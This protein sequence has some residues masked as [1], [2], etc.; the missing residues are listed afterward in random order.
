MGKTVKSKTST[1]VKVVT[2][3]SCDLPPQIVH[4]L[5]I[6]IVPLYIQFGGKTYCDGVDI[7]SDRLYHELAHSSEIPK[8]SAPSPGDF[9]KVYNNLAREANQII[10]IHLSQGYSA[11]F[12]AAMLARSYMEDECRV[13][14]IDS[15]SVS[16]GL[17][18]LVIA[19]AK[20]AQE[21]KDLDQ[22]TDLVNHAIQRVHLFGKIDDLAHIL[23]G[24]RIPLTRGLILLGKVATAMNVN[25]LGE[26]YDGGKVR[27]PAFIFG[28]A[29]ALNRLK[30]WAESFAPVREIAIAHSTK[31]EEAEML[32]QRLEPLFPRERILITRFGCVTSTYVG[33]G[34][35]AIALLSGK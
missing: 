12:N 10:S 14:I 18:L 20:A 33:P 2:D 22:I 30:R 34:T 8:T 24:R 1:M 32:A 31:P 16:V 13:E 27:S 26:L 23:K 21:G 5:D 28:Q 6:T 4:S 19:A 29:R 25:P 9:I 11:T 15:N 17:G 7:S 3:S 35:L